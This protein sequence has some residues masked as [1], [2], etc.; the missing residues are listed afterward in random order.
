MLLPTIIWPTRSRNK[1]ESTTPKL[2]YESALA[3]KPDYANAHNNLGNVLK[4][5]GKFDDAMA[6]YRRAIAINPDYAEAHFNRAEINPSSV[7]TPIWR[8]WKRSP[9]RELPADKAVYIHFALAKA[10]DD[11]GDYARAF[12][13]LRQGNALKRRQVDYQEKAVLNLFQRISTVFDS[14]LFQ[15]FQG[16]GDP[17]PVPVFVLGMPRSGST[18]VEQILA[19]HPQIHGAGE[20]TALEKMEAERSVHCR[21]STASVSRKHS[22]SGRVSLRRLAQAYLGRLPDSRTAKSGSST[23]CSATS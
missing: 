5:Q 14:S 7:A 13:H 21:R 1:T 18:L 11:V 8:R 19:S 10:L 16:Q 9:R 12:E 6:H 4:E 20:V 22:R 23:S 17:S 2:H 15:R 3:L